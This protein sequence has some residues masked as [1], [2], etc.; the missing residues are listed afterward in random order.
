MQILDMVPQTLKANTLC[1]LLD[2]LATFSSGWLAKCSASLHS[3]FET[4]VEK[5]LTLLDSVNNTESL[6][7]LLLTV[8]SRTASNSLPKSMQIRSVETTMKFHR[9][10]L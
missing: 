7:Q 9:G 4:L 3:V 8:V 1:L 10:S 5:C 6:S 2:K